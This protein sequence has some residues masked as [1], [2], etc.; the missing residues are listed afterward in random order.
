M[1]VGVGYS[2]RAAAEVEEITAFLLEHS[3][4]AAQR[5]TASIKR[6]EA[7]LADFPNSG[8]AG[9]TAAYCRRLHP[10]VSPA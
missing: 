8:P 5:F 2:R 3:Q 10:L 4:A 6:A 1:T 9:D 7:Q